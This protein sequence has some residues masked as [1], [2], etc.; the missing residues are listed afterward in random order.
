MD[1]ISRSIIENELG[2]EL[3][4]E[5]NFLCPLNSDP[6]KLINIGHGIVATVVKSLVH[7]RID[8]RKKSLREPTTGLDCSPLL[9]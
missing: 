7:V 8:L 1:S 9:T 2:K 6:P 4:R 5:G 3:I